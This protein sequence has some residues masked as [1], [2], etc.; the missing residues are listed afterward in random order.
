[1]GRVS[2]CQ[3]NCNTIDLRGAQVNKR[4]SVSLSSC[5]NLSFL[6][7]GGDHAIEC[8]NCC[9]HGVWLLHSRKTMLK[10]AAVCPH[11]SKQNTRANPIC[12]MAIRRYHVKKWNCLTH[13]RR[14]TIKHEKAFTR[15][16]LAYDLNG[17][18][19]LGD[20]RMDTWQYTLR[21]RCRVSIRQS[22]SMCDQVIPY[23]SQAHALPQIL[24]CNRH[25][26]HN[27]PFSKRNVHIC[28]HFCYKLVR[29]CIC[30]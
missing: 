10:S 8:W 6:W 5:P 29:C 28:A 30:V 11:C 3:K 13:T 21:A 16:H 4:E 23:I 12:V 24:Q 1:M 14:W 22:L 25:I 20:W 2:T 27:A 17:I 18:T 19:Q 7:M 9:Y 15:K 26:S